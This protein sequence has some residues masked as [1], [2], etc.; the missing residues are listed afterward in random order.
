VNG[1]NRDR[2]ALLL[3]LAF[4][5]SLRLFHLTA[6]FT[7]WHA[8]RQ[9]DTVGMAR[10]FYE[11]SFWPFDPQVNWGGRNGYL[12]A[13]C[14]LIPAL[15]AV[16]FRI[17]GPHE[18]AGRLIIIAFSIGL[19]WATY[20]LALILDG[21]HSVARAAAFL[22]AVS[23][24]AIFFGRIV[25]PD[26]PMM[27]FT[28]LALVGFA[29]FSRRGSLRWM[30]TG[31]LALTVACLL[32]LPAIFVGP[33]IVA[34]LVGQRGWSAFRDPRV[35][36]AG[37]VPLALTGAWY[38]RAHVVFERTG[39]TMGILGTPAKIYPAY[40]SPGPWTNVFSKWATPALLS[41]SGFYARMFLRF[42][43]LL[44]L[45]IGFVGAVLGAFLW[46]APNRRAMTVW[47]MS[48]TAFFFMTANVQRGH[49][50]YQ[51]PFVVVAAMFFGGA[52]WPL[53]DDA[54]LTRHLGGGRWLLPSYAVIIALLAISSIYSSG[55]IR[56]FF[57]PQDATERM[58]QA[59][60][61]ID[62]ITDDNDLAVVVD[63]YGIM[64]PILLYFAH[65]KGWSFEPTDV[66]P[67]VIDNLRRL[68]AR[69]FVTTR[70]R[71]LQRERPEA[72]AF[73][74]SY[75][76]LSISGVPADTRLID[77]RLRK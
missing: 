5:A 6:P 31:A 1:S 8:W 74:E 25:I 30:V 26:T 23:P 53:F 66:S 16:V 36:M 18:I 68:G 7:D 57:E 41:D 17:V 60:R 67:A 71:E 35:W 51:L 49:E 73:L 15:I 76:D 72:A 69:Y 52:A 13:E 27:F 70:W 14:P 40:V 37:I 10:G 42:Y 9:I 47:L 20:T 54:W 48:L 55:A 62:V 65:L 24:A 32:K 12:E 21:R 34:L 61:A 58:R 59:G 50:Y 77:L 29:E 3:I 33:A 75:Q 64:S 45:P 22:I 44:L 46:K 28:V 43:N 38:W 19:V 63:D 4:A 56:I 11:G 2:I 39:L